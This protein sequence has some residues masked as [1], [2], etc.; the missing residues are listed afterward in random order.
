MHIILGLLFGGLG[1]HNFYSGHNFRGAVKLIVILFT[2]FMDALTGF[3]TGFSMV[4]LVGI[5]IWALG[6][7]IF[8]TDDASGN[9]MT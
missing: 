3:R 7:L 9:R 5:S 1:F 2:F 6:E 8:V 4:A